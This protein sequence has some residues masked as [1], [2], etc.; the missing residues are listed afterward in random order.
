MPRRFPLQS[1][2]TTLATAAPNLQEAFN[3]KEGWAADDLPCDENKAPLATVG[4]ESAVNGPTRDL[5]DVLAIAASID[6]EAL[7]GVS[8]VFIHAEEPTPPYADSASETEDSDS[9]IPAC[10]EEGSD[11]EEDDSIQRF[12]AFANRSRASGSGLPAALAALSRTVDAADE[13][14]EET[15]QLFVSGVAGVVR[16]K[17]HIQQAVD[18]ILG[19]RAVPPSPDSSQAHTP[20]YVDL[21]Y[22]TPKTAEE[23]VLEASLARLAA[24]KRVGATR[25]DGTGTQGF[26]PA[27][28]AKVRARRGSARPLRRKLITYLCE[29]AIYKECCHVGIGYPKPAAIS[30]SPDAV[31]LGEAYIA[32]Y[33]M[34]GEKSPRSVEVTLLHPYRT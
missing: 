16:E 21:N 20:Q 15:A 30:L 25:L 22:G 29:L 4:V 18:A 31:F 17:R 19:Q 24:F 7:L 34:V 23:L 14:D 12:L 2:A 10:D 9:D 1:L 26:A 13:N 32:E 27:E 33:G 28:L 8:D 5:S 6:S 3:E 11:S